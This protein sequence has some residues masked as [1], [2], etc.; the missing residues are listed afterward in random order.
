MP[1]CTAPGHAAVKAYL[2]ES[3]LVRLFFSD[4]RGREYI[5]V[6]WD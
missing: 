5:L 4:Q 2:I 3:G 1:T 6:Q